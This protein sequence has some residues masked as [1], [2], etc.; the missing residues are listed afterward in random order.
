MKKSRVSLFILKSYMICTMFLTAYNSNAE[1]Y[2]ASVQ[3][4]T[5]S[6]VL[7]FENQVVDFGRSIMKKR[8]D[9][10]MLLSPT[11]ITD[12]TP[13]NVI[14]TASSNNT[15]CPISNDLTPGQYELSG[16]KGEAITVSLIGSNDRLGSAWGFEPKGIFYPLGLS[17]SASGSVSATVI[18][19][20]GA[21]T[22]VSLSAN[23]Q[24]TLYVGGVLTINDLSTLNTSA[25]LISTFIIDVIY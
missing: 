12:T 13:S 23:G 7:V 11:S 21:G 8:G 22:Q 14:G 1:T 20:G 19:N 4:E 2:T 18:P 25:P 24:A 16:V 15:I 17:E 6:P 5:I 3:F 9:C 10:E